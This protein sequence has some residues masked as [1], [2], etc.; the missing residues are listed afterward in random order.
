MTIRTVAAGFEKNVTL[1]L[2]RIPWL[3][4]YAKTHGWT[5]VIAWAHRI[6]GLLLILYLWI[7]IYTL[8]LLFSP[9]QF[10]A[11]M[12]LFQIALF[13]VLEWALSIPVIFHACNGARLIMYESFGNRKDV[14]AIR[15]VCFISVGYV[16]LLGLMMLLGNQTVTPAFFWLSALLTS[17]CLCYATASRTWR[18]S[19]PVAWKL[20]RI[21]G[22]FLLIMIPAHL[23]YMHL[24]PSAG[25][26]ATL[27]IARMK[28]GLVKVV[29]LLLIIATLY[30]GGYGII[31]IIKDYLPSRVIRATLGLLVSLLMISFAWVGLKLIFI[32]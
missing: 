23:L 29:D 15:W 20:Q 18:T 9:E 17:A 12:K 4:R 8:S 13:V 5:F 3:G 22:S 30:H 19:N 31:S 28:N 27:I 11:K 32:V 25:H 26:E 7:H 10:S 2:M 6:S 21:S 1:S 16:L 24:N 14:T